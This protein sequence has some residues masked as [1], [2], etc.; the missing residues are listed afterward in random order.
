MGNFLALQVA[1]GNALFAG[2]GAVMLGVFCLF[3]ATNQKWQMAS[4]ILVV[5]GAIFVVAS[6]APFRSGFILFGF[7][8]LLEFFVSDPEARPSG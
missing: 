4:R 5:V 8:E 3:T 7:P 1:S 6:A 2:V